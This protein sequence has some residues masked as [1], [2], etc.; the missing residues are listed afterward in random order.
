MC[1]RG[2]IMETEEMNKIAKKMMSSVD[3][4]E[5]P[6]KS[7]AYRVFLEMA[8]DHRSFA[9]QKKQNAATPS[10]IPKPTIDTN[11]DNLLQRIVEKVNRSEHHNIMTM[12]KVKD[13]ALYVLK[14]C[15]DA[16]NVDGL[17]PP[18]ISSILDQVFRI[19]ATAE[20]ISMA[21]SSE[22]KYVDRKPKSAGK[23]F[24]YRIMAHG[25]KYLETIL[26]KGEE[27]EG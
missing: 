14:I 15:K 25:E 12:A 20:A 8:I 18:Q 27:N 1:L 10:V 13:Q 21:L 6:Y 16:A 9:G 3:D 26:K 22:T 2:G 7:I 17:T 23:G 5:E 19:K 11:D 24:V 4:L